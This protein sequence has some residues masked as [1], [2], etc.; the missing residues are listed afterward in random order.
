MFKNLKS[1]LDLGR[2]KNKMHSAQD[3]VAFLLWWCEDGCEAVHGEDAL[4][5]DYD[6]FSE[7][8]SGFSEWAKISKYDDTPHTGNCYAKEW[9]CMRCYHDMW[10]GQAED[11][12]KDLKTNK[13]K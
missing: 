4:R 9:E 5:K 6:L 10:H 1:I 3:A 7:V 8:E 12:I 2:C 13:G 11:L